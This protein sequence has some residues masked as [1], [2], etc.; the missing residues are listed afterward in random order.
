MKW[1]KLFED[2]EGSKVSI[3]NIIDCIEK[4]GF[5]YTDIVKGYPQN[6]P[7]EPLKP[8]DIGENGTIT[9]DLDGNLY[10]VEL[11]DV[12]KIDYQ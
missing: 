6:D 7:K 11:K 5:I 10:E 1:L 4:D 8:V 2:F 12:N 9:I 3:E